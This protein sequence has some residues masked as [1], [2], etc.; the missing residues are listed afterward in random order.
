M[1]INDITAKAGK[2]AK[3]WRV[4]RGIGSG[5][6]KMSGRGHKGGGARAGCS[7]RTLAEGGGLPLFRRVPIRGFSNFKFETV[8]Q[9]VNVVDL[10]KHFA[11]GSDVTVAAICEKGLASSGKG[12]VKVL[13]GG[14][15]SKKLNVTADAFSDSAAR[16]ITEA[17]GQT[18]DLSGNLARRV[19]EKAHA[20]I[21]ARFVAEAAAKAEV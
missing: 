5:S 17:G 20:E 6:G 15:V 7:G 2:N 10:D 16:K 1:M 4:G 13:G 18:T 19:K 3:R 21:A 14:A 8:Y 12:P 11:D 9:P